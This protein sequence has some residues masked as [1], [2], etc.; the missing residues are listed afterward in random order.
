MVITSIAIFML[1][2]ERVAFDIDE[3]ELIIAGSPSYTKRSV[4]RI[5]I[6]S[7]SELESALETLQDIMKGLNWDPSVE[8]FMISLSKT[9]AVRLR[10]DGIFEAMVIMV[11]IEGVWHGFFEPQA[12]QAKQRMVAQAT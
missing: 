9:R 1:E 11:E 10:G 2:Y 8:P 12:E 3:R 4:R 7:Y 5:S 6:T